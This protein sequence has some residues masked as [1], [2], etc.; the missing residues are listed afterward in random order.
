MDGLILAFQ[1][2]EF[3]REH[4]ADDVKMHY[5]VVGCGGTPANIVP[6]TAEASFY[7]RSYNR[8]YLNTVRSSGLKSASGRGHDD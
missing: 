4:V 5:T 8:T 2:I 6:E 1:G 3:L 7:V